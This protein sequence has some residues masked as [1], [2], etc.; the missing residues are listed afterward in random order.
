MEQISE[1]ILTILMVVVTTLLSWGV[2]KLT[3]FIDNK[4]SDSKIKNMLNEAIG[5]VTRVVKEVTQTYVDDLKNKNMF[6]KEAQKRA[7]ELAKEKVRTQLK[8]STKEYIE[9]NFNGFET[10]LATTIEAKLY[11][12]K[13]SK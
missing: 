6:D 9:T 2:A 1:C 5:V 8:Q 10:W 4:V 3:K 12:L 13:E 11:D 7:L